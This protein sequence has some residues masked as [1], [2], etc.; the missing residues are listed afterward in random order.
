VSGNRVSWV[1]GLGVLLLVGTGCQRQYPFKLECTVQDDTG[2]P[3][4]GVK[5]VLDTV[6]TADTR[7]QLDFGERIMP[8]KTDGRVEWSFEAPDARQPN[9][10]RRWYLKLTRDGYNPQR[11][12]VSPPEWPKGATQVTPIVLQARMI[13][14]APK[15]GKQ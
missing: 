12:D 2:K 14:L 5:A 8:T 13:P 11:V 15:S 4:D 9:A 10:E 6:G 1:I 3:L 7:D